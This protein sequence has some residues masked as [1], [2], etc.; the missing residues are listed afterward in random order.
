VVV[1]GAVAFVVRSACAVVG[2]GSVAVGVAVAAR[3]AVPIAQRRFPGARAV[4]REDGAVAREDGAVQSS[5][6]A[7]RLPAGQ[8]LGVIGQQPAERRRPEAGE[9]RLDGAERHVNHGHD[10][11][12]RLPRGRNGRRRRV[13]CA[14]GGRV[15]RRDVR[16]YRPGVDGPRSGRHGSRTG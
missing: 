15:R 7:V 1:A 3:G 8:P 2:R 11:E 13:G 6:D 12:E 4:A 14:R 10:Q 5:Q 9:E 16:V